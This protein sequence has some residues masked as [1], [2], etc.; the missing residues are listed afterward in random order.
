MRLTETGK[1]FTGDYHHLLLRDWLLASLF[2]LLPLWWLQSR[3]VRLRR[4]ARAAKEGA[5]PCADCRYD[6]RATP[7]DESGVRCPECGATAVR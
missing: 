5:V 7:H 2:A 4:A 3:L 6:L 1:A